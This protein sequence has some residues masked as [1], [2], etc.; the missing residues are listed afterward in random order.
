M[1]LLEHICFYTLPYVPE[2]LNH[3]SFFLL[4]SS[5][6]F[7]WQLLAYISLHFLWFFQSYLISAP[8]G[9]TSTSTLFAYFS[10]KL[11]VS[12][13]I[14]LAHSW[15]FSFI[16]TLSTSLETIAAMWLSKK[17]SFFQVSCSGE[18]HLGT[19]CTVLL[20]RLWWIYKH[21][22]VSFTPSWR[23]G[24]LCQTFLKTAAW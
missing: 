15:G 5:I 18:L 6:P 9:H 2:P 12:L 3:G 22:F 4:Y 19:A 10:P 13:P 14:L 20:D 7:T 11:L 8:L 17:S 23:D 21:F 24:L 1:L 16:L